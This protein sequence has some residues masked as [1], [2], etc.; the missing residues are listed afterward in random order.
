VTIAAPHHTITNTAANTKDDELAGAVKLR[1]DE[2]SKQTNNGPHKSPTKKILKEKIH[3]SY[4]L[5]IFVKYFDYCLFLMAR[6]QSLILTQLAEHLSTKIGGKRSIN[7]QGIISL[8]IVSLTGSSNVVVEPKRICSSC[9]I[10][11]PN[12]LLEDTTLPLEL[13]LSGAATIHFF[14][15]L[16]IL[17]MILPFIS[18]FLFLSLPYFCSSQPIL[19]NIHTSTPV[20]V[21]NKDFTVYVKLTWGRGIQDSNVYWRICED[22]SCSNLALSGSVN[23]TDDTGALLQVF[24][25]DMSETKLGKRHYYV[26]MS[27]DESFP[28]EATSRSSFDVKIVPGAVTLLPPLVTVVF[29]ATTRN[30]LLSLYMGVYFAALLIW[31]YN[32]F[33]AFINS[34]SDL[35]IKSFSDTD[36]IFIVLFTWILSGMISCVMKSGGGEGLVNIMAKYAKSPR[37][38]MLVA[39]SLGLMIFFDDYAN[40]LIVGQT[41]RPIIDSLGVSRE[42]LAFLV[43]S[44]VMTFSLSSY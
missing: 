33:Y 10:I 38:G 36:H 35:I 40:T 23:Q 22:D 5:L 11:F 28:K 14:F 26:D 24:D 3:S 18:S 21:K 9:L 43:D 4:I 15:L 6:V 7:F 34:F 29:A 20:G 16:I 2:R 17:T 25:T 42:K 12:Q 31:N 37:S 30:V 8:T 19:G 13:V 32:P 39:F 44:T 41:V 27:Y 1:V